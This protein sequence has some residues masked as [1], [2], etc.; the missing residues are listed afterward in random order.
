MSS[1]L[2]GYT[3]TKSMRSGSDKKPLDSERNTDG[4]QSSKPKIP[5]GNWRLSSRLR[6]KFENML[7]TTWTSVSDRYSTELDHG[8][9][10]YSSNNSCAHTQKFSMLLP[11]LFAPENL[12]ML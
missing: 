3:P 7:S 2:E 9:L 10:T 4:I 11:R 8:I 12:K 6:W 5:T 1:D